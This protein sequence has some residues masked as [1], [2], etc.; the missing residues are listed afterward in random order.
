MPWIEE[1][2]KSAAKKIDLLTYLRSNEPH[3]LVES[4]P[5][6]YRTDTNGS[7]VISNGLWIWNRGKIGGRSALDYLMKVRGMGFVDAVQAVLGSPAG[8]STVLSGCDSLPVR[9]VVKSQ[10]QKKLY[11]PRKVCV[12]HKA[13]KYL[14]ERGIHSD[15]I[16]YCLKSGILYESVYRSKKEP[17]LDGKSTCVFVGRNSTGVAKFAAQRGISIDFKRDAPGSDKTYN[18]N[19]PARNPNSRALAVFEAP[20]DLLSHATMVR[21][22][23]LDFDGY[24]LSLGGTS[25]VALI[26]YLERNPHIENISLCLDNDAAGLEAVEKITAVLADDKRFKHI[27][28]TP[29]LPKESG[30]DYNE[31]LRK[32]LH[33]TKHRQV[34]DLKREV[35]SSL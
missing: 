12:P 24:R 21:L 4:G 2:Q 32:V 7:L 14:G 34:S 18:F 15:I 27:T 11:L 10:A 28:A 6:E 16:G 5:G 29:N 30:H 8:F 20:V 25:D 17:E 35:V 1:E 33:Q 3:E 13:V 31:E 26:A 22:G 9:K 19:L 23:L